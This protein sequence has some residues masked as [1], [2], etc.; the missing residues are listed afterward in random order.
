L[1]IAFFSNQFADRQGHGIARYAHQ[2]FEA[3]LQVRPTLKVT[4]VAAW[5]SRDAD[6][7]RELREKSGL[8]L[9][10]WGRRWTPLAWTFIDRPPIE[11]W[12][13]NDIDLVHAVS[14][15]YPVSTRKPYVVTVHDIGPLTHP[16]FFSNTRPWVMKR[17][18]KQALKKA[19]AIICVSK[20]TAD[21]LES[22][23]GRSLNERLHVVP[24]GVS[25]QFFEAKNPD[26]LASLTGLP[27]PGTPFIVAT[28]KISP[29]KNVGRIIKALSKLNGMIPHHLILVG[30]SGWDME[31]V[32]K[33]M[34][35]STVAGRVHLIGYVSD[36]QL[37]ALYSSASAYVHP[38]LFEG[39]GLT[40][41]EAMAAGCP[42]VTSNVSSLPE[43]A[44]DAALLVDPYDVDT[45]AEAIKSLCSDFSLAADLVKRGRTRARAFTW[46]RCA[47]QV[48]CIYQR[49]V[50]RK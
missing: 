49:V 41:L 20:S 42:V 29:R 3:L 22:Y 5:S 43:V 33:E 15:G 25:P 1:H 21:D 30:G 12:I 27:E 46:E 34:N 36:E 38:S 47:E 2:L 8:K 14:L 28:G 50:A 24:E 45:I 31:E 17:S 6:G 40:V 10:P 7:I 4:P 37:H 48:A 18:L 23:V 44:G 32:L 13:G 19:A 9:L 35:K 11:H 39:F 16:E 26:C